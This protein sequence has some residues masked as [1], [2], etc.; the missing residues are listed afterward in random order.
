MS[1]MQCAVSYLRIAGKVKKEA[2][3]EYGRHSAD[4]KYLK[5]VKRIQI[6]DQWYISLHN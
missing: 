2:D 3:Y 6:P 4:N 5:M 1:Y